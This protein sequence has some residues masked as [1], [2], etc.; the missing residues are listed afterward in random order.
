MQLINGTFNEI[1]GLILIHIQKQRSRCK[2]YCE[3]EQLNFQLNIGE[4]DST[5]L[6]LSPLSS[7][8]LLAILGF[9]SFHESSLGYIELLLTS[10]LKGS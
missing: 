10:A 1:V 6:N 5:L 8:R 9:Y 4:G 2:E 3:E 7:I